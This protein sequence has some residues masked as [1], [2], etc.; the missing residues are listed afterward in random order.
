MVDLSQDLEAFLAAKRAEAEA[1]ESPQGAPSFNFEDSRVEISFYLEHGFFEEARGAVEV[2]DGAFR[3][4]P[5]IIE[6]R[7]LVAAYTAGRPFEASSKPPAAAQERTPVR[8][9]RPGAQA[10]DQ[11]EAASSPAAPKPQ[12]QPAVAPSALP[13]EERRP[14]GP[15][16][17]AGAETSTHLLSDVTE[18]VEP[19]M[20]QPAAPLAAPP[21]SARPRAIPSESTDHAPHT[22]HAEVQRGIPPNAADDSGSKPGSEEDA[23]AHFNLGMAFWEMKLLDQAIGEFQ[24][25]VNSVEKTPQAANYLQA[26]SLLASCFMEK[27]MAPIAVKWYCRAL[28]APRLD[29][30]ARLALQYDLGVAY[31]RAGDLPRALERFSEVY[32]QKIDFR[33]V[34]EKIRAL[35][36]KAS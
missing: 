24:K 15:P 22:A 21:S 4:D 17:G 20:G 18:A 30:E 9:N 29:R 23:E 1:S 11:R 27:D 16:P 34:A 8:V 35:Q 19:A 25:A 3:G 10:A 6:L 31:E 26:C 13:G 32:G 7:S 5:R 14:L 36:Q 33:D 12:G 28:E 2:L